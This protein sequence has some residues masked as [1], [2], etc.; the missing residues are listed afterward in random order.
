MNI[1]E[2]KNLKKMDVGGLSGNNLP[3]T[4]DI[5]LN[6]WILTSFS[7]KRSIREDCSTAKWETH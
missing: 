1:M 5:A 6:S 4:E 7:S 3:L 2:A